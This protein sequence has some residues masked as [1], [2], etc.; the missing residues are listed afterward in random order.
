MLDTFLAKRDNPL[1]NKVSIANLL[2]KRQVDQF[3]QTSMDA[4]G[5]SSK[6]RILSLLKQNP[7]KETYLTEI[8]NPN[9]RNVLWH[10]YDSR[11]IHW[12]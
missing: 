11:A 12:K 8:N 10:N 3:H 2:L 6:L 9:H 4:I 1:N 5:Q 7:G